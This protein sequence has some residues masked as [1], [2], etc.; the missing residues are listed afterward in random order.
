MYPDDFNGCDTCGVLAGRPC[1][2]RTVDDD[3]MPTHDELPEPHD[4]RTFH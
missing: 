2:T 4:G 3:G 1:I